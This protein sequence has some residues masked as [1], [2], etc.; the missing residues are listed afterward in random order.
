MQPTD[1]INH[2]GLRFYKRHAVPFERCL[3]SAIERVGRK[4]Q[5]AVCRERIASDKELEALQNIR[6]PMEVIPR[7]CV[8]KKYGIIKALVLSLAA[9]PRRFR[10]C[11]LAFAESADV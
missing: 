9:I 7:P 10:S 8:G 11:K 6:K 5:S 3:S 2:V 1:P 4:Q